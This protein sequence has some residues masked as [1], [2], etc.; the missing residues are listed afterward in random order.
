VVFWSVIVVVLLVV[1]DLDAMQ[2]LE[3]GTLAGRPGGDQG[4]QI[5]LVGPAV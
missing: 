1:G 3:H 5:L 2:P 4:E